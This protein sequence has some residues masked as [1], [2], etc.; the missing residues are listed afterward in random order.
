[1]LDGTMPA[2]STVWGIEVPIR[3][4]GRKNW[5]LELRA[6]AVRRIAEGAGIREI[7]EEIGANKSLV[8]TWVKKTDAAAVQGAPAFVELLLP[9]EPARK[10]LA[11]K[12]T[13]AAASETRICHILIGDADIAISPDFPAESLIGILRAVRA[14]Q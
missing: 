6:M 9:D 14:S 8:S 2:K 4:N 13:A 11:A 1:M 7:A 12:H 10:K 3:D 5:P